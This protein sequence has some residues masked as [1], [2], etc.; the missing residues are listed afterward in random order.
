MCE[1]LDTSKSYLAP[2]DI[3][4]VT[5]ADTRDLGLGR[6]DIN[7]LDTADSGNAVVNASEGALNTWSMR[8]NVRDAERV[9][10]DCCQLP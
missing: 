7:S 6:A 10:W 2:S 8:F 1:T 9:R 5:V 3:L 4:S